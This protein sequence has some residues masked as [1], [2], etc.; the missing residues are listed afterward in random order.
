LDVCIGNVACTWVSQSGVRGSVG[1]MSSLCCVC[2]RP[3]SSV[4]LC[5]VLSSGRWPGIFLVT[6]LAFI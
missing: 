6:S 3:L 4:E 5:D 1:V 2:V